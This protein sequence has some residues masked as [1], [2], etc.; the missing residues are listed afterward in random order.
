[1]RKAT[2]RTRTPEGINE[3]SVQMIVADAPGALKLRAPDKQAR[4]GITTAEGGK[5]IESVAKLSAQTLDFE[6]GVEKQCCRW[7][8]SRSES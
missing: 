7:W 3:P 2:A 4:F 8:Q 5:A 1:M 6:I